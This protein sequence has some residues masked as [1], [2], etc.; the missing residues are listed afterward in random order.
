MKRVIVRVFPGNGILQRFIPAV[1]RTRI[2]RLF[3]YSLLLGHPGECGIYDT[4]HRD[5]T[6][7]DWQPTFTQ[8]SKTV[9][10]VHETAKQTS[11]IG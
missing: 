2:T 7:R 4:V 9:V 3:R 8:Q 1:L 5:F 6:G 11:K 10:F